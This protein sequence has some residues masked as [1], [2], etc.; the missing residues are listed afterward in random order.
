MELR[1]A[2]CVVAATRGS[3]SG[4]EHLLAKEKVAG[5]N[6]VSRSNPP[7]IWEADFSCSLGCMVVVG[8]LIPMDMVDADGC[9]M[10]DCAWALEVGVSAG[11]RGQVVKA[12]VCK[13][14]ITGSN[15]VVA[16]KANL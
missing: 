14:L 15:P 7:P 6:P 10:I 9:V 12:R 3:G 2:R 5:S 8:R 16:S 4:V 11:R 13:T 1:S